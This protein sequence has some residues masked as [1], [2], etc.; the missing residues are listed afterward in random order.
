MNKKNIYTL[1]IIAF[2]SIISFGI[3][4]LFSYTKK[5]DNYSKLSIVKD[6]NIYF[7]VVKNVNYFIDTLK[8]KDNEKIFSLLDI[9]YIN[10]NRINKTNVSNKFDNIDK[11]VVFSGEQIYYLNNN[12][13]YLFLVNGRLINNEKQSIINNNYKI[14]MIIDYNKLLISFYPLKDDKD[15][16]YVNEFNIEVNRYNQLKSAKALSDKNMCKLYYEKFIEYLS[17][18]V[19]G[20]YDIVTDGIKDKYLLDGFVNRVNDNYK[21]YK[22][23]FYSCDVEYNKENGNRVFKLIDNK[24]NNIYFYEEGVMNFKVKIDLD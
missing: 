15:I 20:L 21:N 3:I 1:L 8:E 16:D 11:D 13:I 12:N 2:I 4:Y 5:T 9:N 7:S 10:K 19:S 22:Y 17:N 14:A 24:K 18:D 23:N 6:Y